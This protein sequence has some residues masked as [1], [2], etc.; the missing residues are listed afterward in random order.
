MPLQRPIVSLLASDAC[1]TPFQV[2]VSVVPM[3][4]ALARQWHET[5]QPIVNRYYS[6]AAETECNT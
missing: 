4:E 2:K 5:V 1:G 3:T 6:A